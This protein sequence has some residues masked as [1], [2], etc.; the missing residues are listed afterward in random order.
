MFAIDKDTQQV[1]GWGLNNYHQLE[2]SETV[3]RYHPCKLDHTV[4]HDSKTVT[5]SGGEHHTVMCTDGVVKVVGR[6][7][8]GRVGL[9]EDAEEP[10]NLTPLRQLESVTTVASGGSCS[11]AVT[12]QGEAYSWG[13]GTNLQLGSG[14]EEDR[15]VPEKVSG[16]QLEGQ[17]VIGVSVGGQH[18][19][20]LVAI[21]TDSE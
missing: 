8:Y 6:K 7:E 10:K 18:T 1:Y 13:M 20:L 2:P 4:S 14:E 15:W 3:A 16:K 12:K 17:K 5:Y 21:E 19:A 11:F 9:G